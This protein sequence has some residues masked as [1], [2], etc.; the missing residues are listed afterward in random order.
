[1]VHDVQGPLLGKIQALPEVAGR[2]LDVGCGSGRI[3]NQVAQFSGSV[4]GI[5]EDASLV[6]AARENS[7]ARNVTYLVGGAQKLEFGKNEFDAVL[8]IKSL[9]HVPN[10][11]Q[12]GALAEACRVIRPGG[13]VLVVEPVYKGGAYE[14]IVSIYHDEQTVRLSALRAIRETGFRLFSVVREERLTIHYL[15]EG[16]EDLY[17]SEIEPKPWIHWNESYRPQVE[18]ILRG[19][20]RDTQ[21]NYSLDYHLTCWVLRKAQS[22]PS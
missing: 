16:F 14:E 12:A 21:G 9:H 15:C 11:L 13:G 6:R 19:A 22:E 17:R 5:D 10:E 8:F 20:P 4:V 2:V 3:T 7:A 1:M 18:G